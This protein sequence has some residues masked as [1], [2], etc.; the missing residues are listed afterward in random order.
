MMQRYAVRP[1]RGS[2]AYGNR[3]QGGC[4]GDGCILLAIEYHSS[5]TSVLASN[6]ALSCSTY[7]SRSFILAAVTTSAS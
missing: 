3:S 1:E 5:D 2:E 6:I 4:I 7:S